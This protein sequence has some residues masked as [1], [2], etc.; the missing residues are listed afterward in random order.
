MSRAHAR[1]PRRGQQRPRRHL[2]EAGLPDR[3]GRRTAVRGHG[4]AR[5][6]PHRAV[7][8]CRAAGYGV[9]ASRRS[10]TPNRS[11]LGTSRSSS[12]RSSDDALTAPPSAEFSAPPRPAAESRSAVRQAET[13]E[14]LAYT[15]TQAA[16]ALGVSRATFIR[17][18]LPLVETIDMPWGT[19]LIPVDELERVLDER[20]RQASANGHSSP[21][22]AQGDGSSR[23]RRSD[24]GRAHVGTQLRR[25]RARA[26]RGRRSDSPSRSP[27]VAVHGTSR[28]RAL[29][30]A[31]IRS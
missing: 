30:S 19:R 15:R 14:R 28:L 23:H 21:A 25:H 8:A 11:R 12:P 29:M 17:R 22:R 9:G 7:Y 5:A 10:I 27:V 13:V 24:P 31:R 4:Q 3:P 16:D 1:S 26:Q 2:N 18:V 20:R 6:A